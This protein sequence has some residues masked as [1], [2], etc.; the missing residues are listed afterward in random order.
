[1]GSWFSLYLRIISAS[2]TSVARWVSEVK[3]SPVDCFW[4]AMSPKV[5][6]GGAEWR[7]NT[8]HDGDRR[9]AITRSSFR[10]L[11]CNHEK[12]VTVV[13]TKSATVTSFF[14]LFE[15]VLVYQPM[16]C[17]CC[18]DGGQHLCIK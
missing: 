15:G 11:P 2:T 10:Q 9:E 14:A 18:A 8:T 7:L 4:Q 16:A 17:G 12:E 1:M 6:V 13:D 3:N 5:R